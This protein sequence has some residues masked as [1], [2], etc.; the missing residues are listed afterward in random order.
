MGKGSGLPPQRGSGS[1]KGVDMISMFLQGLFKIPAKDRNLGSLFPGLSHL[2]CCLH[3]GSLTPLQGFFCDSCQQVL[4]HYETSERDIPF[5]GPFTVHALFNWNAGESDMLS[6]LFVVLKGGGVPEVW[7]FYARRFLARRRASAQW[8][9][10]K[11]YIVP[12]PSVKQKEDHAFRWAR[13]LAVEADVEI[14]R[15]FSK[16]AAQKQRGATKK[17]RAQIR[18]RTNENFANMSEDPNEIHWIFVDDIL[19]T[20]ATATAAYQALGRPRHFEVWVLGSRGV[21]LRRT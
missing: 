21:L 4:R 12:A 19:T 6:R 16:V 10:S 1:L 18:L 13:A 8:P 14:L 20:G 15:I 7:Q 9:S 3:C 17:R 5:R 11:I 2:G